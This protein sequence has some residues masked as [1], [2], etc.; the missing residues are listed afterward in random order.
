M[1]TDKLCEFC[2]AEGSVR[3]IAP[4]LVLVHILRP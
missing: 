4:T 1:E 3:Q 2:T